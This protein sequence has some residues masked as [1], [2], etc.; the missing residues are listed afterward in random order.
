MTRIQ[1]AIDVN[2]P[3]HTA[4]QQL[5]QFEQYPRFMEH[6][7]KVQQID[8]SHI[9][10]HTRLR[11]LEGE[12]EAEI[13]EQV[14]EKCIAWRN[15]DAPFR[16]GRIELHALDNDKTRITFTVEYEPQQQGVSQQMAPE[17]EATQRAAQDLARFKKMIE[18]EMGEMDEARTEQTGRNNL[19]QSVGSKTLSQSQTIQSV[20][21]S[22]YAGEEIN[23][24]H[25]S[26]AS[27]AAGAEGWDG[28][29]DP[30]VPDVAVP[31]EAG[32]QRNSAHPADRSS[33]DVKGEERKSRH[34]SQAAT[35]TSLPPSQADRQSA[36][37]EAASHAWLPNLLQSW[38]EPMVLIRRMRDEV[39]HMF[40]KVVGRPL[41]GSKAR[42]DEA[43]STHLWSPAIDIAQQEDRLII[44][45][46]LPGV[47]PEDVRVEI[48]SDKLI[49]EGNRR[50]ET[51][52]N[53]GAY[54]QSE[55]A[56]GQFYRM[57][58]LPHGTDS[59]AASAL[60][61]DGIL[62]VT[63]PVQPEQRGRQL[64]IRTF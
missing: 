17:Q 55:R 3:I 23:D 20:Q 13:I 58:S 1:Q 32:N 7:E 64:D 49:I 33:L 51:S 45:A 61:H 9:R 59:E 29:E 62:Q 24:L 2:V 31:S 12:R 54:R 18:T 30:G 10:W 41:P 5:V 44:S 19:L 47:K 34:S 15:K 63:V 56:Y 27:P 4:Y 53:V 37:R 57:V 35:A 28:N 11:G 40:E 25:P 43:G 14:P 21:H 22:G 60:L 52:H 42:Q 6:V 46:D 48:K 50:A 38:D 39:D 16:G 8:A 26:S 36:T